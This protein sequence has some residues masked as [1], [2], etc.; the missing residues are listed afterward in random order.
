MIEFFGGF[1]QYVTMDTVFLLVFATVFLILGI[2]IGHL[3][4]RW[5]DQDF[6]EWVKTHPLEVNEY[7]NYGDLYE[8]VEE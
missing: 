6:E 4:T 7:G 2:T 3:F 1:Y 5:E 8:E